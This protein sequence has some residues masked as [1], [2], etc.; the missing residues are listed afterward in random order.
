MK[1]VLDAGYYEIYGRKNISR[2]RT[3]KRI[4]LFTILFL[5]L[6][7]LSCK[8]GRTAL[9]GSS[10][11]KTRY[12]IILV[13]GIG[14]R[15]K[16]S[17]LKYWGD[18]PRYLRTR[19]AV[20]VLSNQQAFASH[21]DN[22]EII[23]KTITRFL[24]NNPEYKKVN[25]IAHSKGGIESRYCITLPG[26][27][28]KIAS[29]TTIASPHRG[30]KIADIVMG[31]INSDRS[32]IVSFINAIAGIM[33]DSKPDAYDAGK[34]LTSEYMKQ[35]NQKVPDHKGIFYQSYAA[36][37]NSQY[38][39]P[40]WNSVRKVLEKHDGP[41]DGLVS[42]RSAQWGNYRGVV[43]HK[44][45]PAVSH[46]DIIGMHFVTGVFSFKAEKF[47]GEIIH[48]LKKEGY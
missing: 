26:M 39:N 17:I 7:S 23:S 46:A 24:Q 2:V 35:F 1:I 6:V 47:M 31:K 45:K 5:I 36:E 13:H 40:I 41:N 34:Q 37:I 20:V 42:I 32:V 28:K 16:G 29:L 21:R 44:G 43:K 4:Q 15:D 33:G 12:P 8:P 30:S 18:I 10:Y 38:P 9:E 25:I 27:A 11:C 48:L 14:F 22:G 3:M 19:G